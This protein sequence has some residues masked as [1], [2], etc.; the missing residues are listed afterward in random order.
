RV[1]D[2]RR[3]WTS[4]YGTHRAG[5]PA[6]DSSPET[7][8]R[9]ERVPGTILPHLMQLNPPRRLP[10]Q[11]LQS[12]VSSLSPSTMR[13][14]LLSAAAL[15]T[16][17]AAAQVRLLPSPGALAVT[18]GTAGEA[19]RVTTQSAATGQRQRLSQRYRGI[20]VN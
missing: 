2:M 20:T 16:L 8:G 11:G 12:R 19:M 3:A 18:G 9:T 4:G 10:G 17:P 13:L 1:V 14:L 7:R 5:R 15:F 6:R